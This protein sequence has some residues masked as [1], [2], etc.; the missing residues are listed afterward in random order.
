MF[1]VKY[2]LAKQN[3]LADELSRLPEYERAHATT[4]LSPN[5][6]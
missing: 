2:K 4:L 1:A 6:I 5:G 3:G